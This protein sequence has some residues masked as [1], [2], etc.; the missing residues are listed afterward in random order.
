MIVNLTQ[1]G[2]T[3][4]QQAQGVV[5]LTQDFNV[6]ELLT[7]EALPSLEEIQ[8]RAETLAEIAARVSDTAM[9]GGAPWLMGPLESAL[10]QRGVRPLYAFSIRES[11]E[12]RLPDGSV[13]KT[14]VFKH[15]GFVG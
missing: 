14:N 10:K 7:F 8:A 12:T 9:I 13:Q 5:D 4:A 2:A 11:V 3:P 1:H 15:V 6:S